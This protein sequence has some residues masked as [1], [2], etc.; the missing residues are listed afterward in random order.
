MSDADTTALDL[1]AGLD[2]YT[3]GV[4][5]DAEADAFEETLFVRAAR[6]AAP[7]AEFAE[8]LRRASEWIA[9]R[10]PFKVGNTRAEIDAVRASGLNVSFVDFGD[11]SAPVDLPALAPELDLFTYRLGV[12]LRGY[13]AV[14]VIVET[15]SGQ[16]IKTFRDVSFDPADGALYGMCEAPLAEISFGRGTVISKVMAGHGAQRQLIAT[17]ETRPSRT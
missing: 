5:P 9:R 12:D 7:E 17:F 8:R 6:G 4:M 1:L 16:Y 14:D 2:D 11:G 10:G 15:P 13:D 3:S